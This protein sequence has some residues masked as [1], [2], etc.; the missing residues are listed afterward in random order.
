M[1]RFRALLPAAG[2]VIL[3]VPA[4]APAQPAGSAECAEA[5]AEIARHRL[6]RSTSAAISVGRK[7]ESEC[8]GDD[9]F[10]L[11]YALAR[12]EVAKQVDRL[13]VRDRT[14]TFNGALE[15]LELVKG[16][17][18]ARRSDHYEIFGTLGHIYYETK[19]YEKAVA[20]L[21]ASAP[22]FPRLN[23]ATQRN[24]LFTRGQAEYQLGQ[25][26]EA[27]HSFTRAAKLG[28]PEAMKWS[29]KSARKL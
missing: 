27:R 6:A 19:Q 20:V 24:I 16:H 28:H 2:L 18:L 5:Q 13:D 14:E 9:G 29:V 17:V 7:R 25:Y 8:R 3:L 12:I 11:A 1:S 4:P 22:V 23:P 10:L 15:D 26:N 21:N